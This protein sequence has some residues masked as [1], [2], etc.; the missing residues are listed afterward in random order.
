ML[1]LPKSRSMCNINHI[2]VKNKNL[3]K[4]IKPKK[5]DE[6]K[7]RPKLIKVNKLF[8]MDKY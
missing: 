4:K 5:T 2:N 6:I 1:Q 7:D 3:N 8:L